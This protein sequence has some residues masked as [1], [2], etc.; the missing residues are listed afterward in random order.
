[1][2]SVS[3]YF[4]LPAVAGALTITVAIAASSLAT[5]ALA[6]ETNFP[7]RHRTLQSMAPANCN[8]W[9]APLPERRVK[10]DV[11]GEVRGLTGTAALTIGIDQ[12]GRYTGVVE[13]L[14]NDAAFVRAAKDSLQYWSFV[15]A[16]CDGV[17]VATQAK[18]YFNFR[19]ESFV[20]YGAGSTIN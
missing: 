8:N 20:G 3:R 19:H 2:K 17:A 7:S 1:M 12:S 13:A 14:T 15:P 5:V 6:D 4:S 16:R 18:I 10:V 9:T 11:P